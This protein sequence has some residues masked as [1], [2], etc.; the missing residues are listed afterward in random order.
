MKKM[1]FIAGALM[2][3]VAG[4]AMAGSNLA[5]NDCGAGGGTAD[6]TVNCTNT[7]S[8]FSHASLN[9][10]SSYPNVGATDVYIDVNPASG[11]SAWWNTTPTT[12]RWGSA[13]TEPASGA[14]PAWWGAAPN[15]GITFQPPQAQIINSKMRLRIT[16][17]IAAGEEQAMDPGTEYF[18]G[19]LQMKFNAG[20]FGNTEC[21]AGAAIGIA[22]IVV[23][24]P[25][26][27]DTNEGQ[28]AEVSNCVTFRNP[29]TRQCPGATPTE[30]STWGSIK[31][32]Y[33]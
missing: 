22:N 26:A 18:M 11:V 29:A 24:Q 7:G 21:L 13:G 27:N 4:S 23:L 28:V 17:V 3:V 2:L 32:L 9:P 30:K 19:S 31:A 12:T 16:T 1:V 15:G 33:R 20:S 8:A 5:W 25:G 14:C 6:R 10:S